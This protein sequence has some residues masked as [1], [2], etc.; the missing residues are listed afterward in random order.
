MLFAVSVD[1]PGSHPAAWHDEVVPRTST[2]DPTRLTESVRT[3]ARAG[4]AFAVFADRLAPRHGGDDLRYDA[5]TLA[6]RLAPVTTSIGIVP[7]VSAPLTEPYHVSKAVATLDFISGGRAGWNPRPT[8]DPAEARYAGRPEVASVEERLAW[9]DEH[10]EI[11]RRLWDSWEDDAVIRDVD[12]A[13][14]LDAGKLH[15]VDFRG[16]HFAVRGPSTTPRP[17][18]GHPVTV[19][20]VVDD[21]STA[22]AVRHADVAVVHAEDID[23]L[24]ERRAEVAA[25][26]EAAG[27]RSSTRILGRLAAFGDSRTEAGERLRRR[28]DEIAGPITGALTVTGPVADIVDEVR[29]AVTIA[30][31]DGFLVLPPTVTGGLQVW[32][33]AV[34]PALHLPVP[35][36]GAALR[37]RLGLTRPANSLVAAS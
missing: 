33:D 35:P 7:E 19:I 10:L 1:G 27:R 24:R 26:L 32:T 34:L 29:T 25:A 22:L 23:E 16:R 6:A 8:V 9:A 11:T 14:Y 30:A 5:V 20:D 17:P 28:L 13:R 31:V 36:A 4:F 37:D 12:A 3:A 21:A 18:Q 15:R 2:L